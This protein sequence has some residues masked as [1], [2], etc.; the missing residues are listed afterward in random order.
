MPKVAQ[1]L[2][3]AVKWLEAASDQFSFMH[4]ET[5]EWAV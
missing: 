5:Q 3:P 2:L 4:M 1:K